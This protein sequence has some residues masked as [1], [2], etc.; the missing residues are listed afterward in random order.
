MIF[1]AIYTVKVKVDENKYI[2]T[3][4]QHTL[5]RADIPNKVLNFSYGHTVDDQLLTLDY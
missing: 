1:G 4:V 3:R 5:H 2:H